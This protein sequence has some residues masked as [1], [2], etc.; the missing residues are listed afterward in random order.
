MKKE[1]EME[2]R[3]KISKKKQRGIKERGRKKNGRYPFPILGIDWR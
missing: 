2:I 3:K 1:L